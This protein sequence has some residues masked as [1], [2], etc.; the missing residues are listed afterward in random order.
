MKTTKT[1]LFVNHDASRTG[2]TIILLNFLKWLKVNGNISFQI[3]L[4]HDGPLESEFKAIAPVFVFHK[5]L[6][7]QKRFMIKVLNRLGLLPDKQKKHLKHLQQKIAPYIGLVYANTVTNIEPLTWLANLGCPVLCHVHELEYAIRYCIGEKHFKRIKEYTTHYIAVS[8]AVQD[9]LIRNHS[10]PE[11]RIEIVHEFIPVQSH[12]VSKQQQIRAKIC[13]QY[14]IPRDARIICASGTT[15]WRKGVDLFIQLAQ[16][17]YKR[18]RE[19]PLYLLWVGGKGGGLNFSEL[20]LWHDV[21]NIGLEQYVHFLGE[22]T[23]PLDYFAACDVFALVSREDPFP[24]VCLE[25]ASLA[26]PI[27]CF[28]KAGGMKEFVEND[29]GYVVP[30]LDIEAMAVKI[31]YLLHCLEAC[32]KLGQRAQQKVRERHDLEV[33]APKILNMIEKFLQ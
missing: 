21:K 18:Y 26:K 1:I 4:N 5:E 11:N 7:H 25:A 17:I 24:L 6:P 29:A 12:D 30:Y 31:A 13:E 19:T 2:A 15:D 28:D 3:L 32:Q 8:K 20:E 9:N 27:V 23:N 22:Q 10:I 14:N 33:T 16:A